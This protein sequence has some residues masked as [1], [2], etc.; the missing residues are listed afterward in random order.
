MWLKGP[1]RGIGDRTPRALSA[2]A[3]PASVAISAARISLTIGRTLAA[4]QHASVYYFVEPSALVEPP[5]RR[6]ADRQPSFDVAFFHRPYAC[7]L[8]TP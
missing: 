1:I 7:G 6:I 2:E 4:K 5:N 8:F 3:I